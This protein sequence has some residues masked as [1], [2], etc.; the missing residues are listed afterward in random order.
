AYPADALKAL[1]QAD[2]V[3]CL[4]TFVTDQMELYADVLL[5]ISP[6]SETGGT[7]VNVTGQWQT[8][9][10]ASVPCAESQPAWKVLRVLGNL[11]ELPDFKYKTVNQIHHELKKQVEAQPVSPAIQYPLVAV[12]APAEQL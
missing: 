6:F 8:F 11:F 12:T 9:A 3:V 1:K 4:T 10:P 2:C 5:P 7:Y